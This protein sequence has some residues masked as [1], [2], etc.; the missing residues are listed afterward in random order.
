LSLLD[1]VLYADLNYDGLLDHVQVITDEN[2]GIV[3]SETGEFK[4]KWVADLSKRIADETDD[5][6]TKKKFGRLSISNRLCHVLALSGMPAREELFSAQVCPSFGPQKR[7]DHPS[8]KLQA[9]APLPVEVMDGDSDEGSDVVVA[10]NSGVVSRYQV[11]TGRRQWQL[12]NSD[13]L[14]T[15]GGASEDDGAFSSP[16]VGRIDFLKATYAPWIRPI[17]VTGEDGMAI[18]STGKGGLLASASFPQTAIGKPILADLSGDG[19]TDVVITSA[20]A[21]WGYQ[22]VVRTG[23]SIMLRIMVG[24]LMAFIGLAILRNRFGQRKGVDKR[25]TDS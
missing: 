13:E 18:L 12:H 22:V 7:G 19:T 1:K 14:P 17:V 2:T 16:L 9:A 5:K 15:W 10:L 6:G 11:S 25:S 20:D 4:D 21:I 24:L 8:L 23:G 3:D